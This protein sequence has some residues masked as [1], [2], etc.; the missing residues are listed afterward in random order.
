MLRQFDD[1]TDPCSRLRGAADRF[2]ALACEFHPDRQILA[3]IMRHRDC[4]LPKVAIPGARIDQISAA[5]EDARATLEILPDPDR[6]QEP[7]FFA[8]RM[9]RRW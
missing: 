1:R 6:Q 5:P 3:Q 4:S 7:S 9:A 8:R 2:G